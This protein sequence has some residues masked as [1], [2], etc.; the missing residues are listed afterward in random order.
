MQSVPAVDF[1]FLL[2]RLFEEGDLDKSNK[3]RTGIRTRHVFLY[4]YRRL[5]SILYG[6]YPV[7]FKKSEFIEFLKFYKDDAYYIFDTDD[8][9]PFFSLMAEPIQSAIKKI[10]GLSYELG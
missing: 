4:D 3:Y 6:N 9:K 10:D 5:R 1:P 8:M 2:Y 7:E